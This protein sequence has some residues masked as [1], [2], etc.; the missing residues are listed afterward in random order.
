MAVFATLADLKSHANVSTTA[1][2]GELQDMLDAAAGIVRSLIGTSFDASVHT[3]RLSVNGGTAVLTYRP[4]AGD[5]VLNGGAVTGHSVDADAGLLLDVP[6]VYGP[7]TA[8]Y[9]ADSGVVPAEVQMATLVIAAHLYE[10]QRMPGQ[11]FDS[12]PAGFGGADGQ[13]DATPFRG[14]AI[15]NRALELL[16]WYIKRHQRQF[17]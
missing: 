15:P 2:D 8:T 12:R 17:L 6:W 16:D 4:V 14:F 13:P 1:D 11:A 10:T 5:V 3:E 9:T 7:L